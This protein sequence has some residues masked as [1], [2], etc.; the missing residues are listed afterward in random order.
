MAS[1]RMQQVEYI[2]GNTAR[3][4]A[5]SYEPEPLREPERRRR[6]ERKERRR[7]ERKTH[8]LQGLDLFSFVFL[9]GIMVITL[10]T[11]FDY[12]FVQAEITTAKK[13]IVALENEIIE[14]ENDNI[15]ARESIDSSLD[16]EKVYKMATEELGMVEATSGQVYTYSSKKSNL[17]RQYADI[18][19]G[20]ASR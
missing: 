9:V 17:V 11:C 14:L 4:A 15:A 6:P 16:L 12:L 2:Y 18:P 10:Y 1:R 8:P 3:A 5:P 20:N 7:E 13:K 19:T